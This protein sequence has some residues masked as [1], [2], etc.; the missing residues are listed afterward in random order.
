MRACIEYSPPRVVL[1]NAFVQAGALVV[2]QHGAY[3]CEGLPVFAVMRDVRVRAWSAAANVAGGSGVEL[4]EQLVRAP[5]ALQ[6]L[7]G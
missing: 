5:H 3:S 2:Q 4:H 1:L 6:R 7:Q